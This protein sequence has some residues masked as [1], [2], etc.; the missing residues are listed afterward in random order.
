MDAYKLM[1]LVF[2]DHVIV[3][4]AD[5]YSYADHGRPAWSM[6]VFMVMKIHF[7]PPSA[8]PRTQFP[9]YLLL[10]FFSYADFLNS[11]LISDCSRPKRY[12]ANR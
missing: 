10:S 9:R 2:L 5:H 11:V 6:V 12:S 3:G 4:D 1:G 8:K 7:L